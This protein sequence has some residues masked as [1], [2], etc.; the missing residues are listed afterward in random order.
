MGGIA[1]RYVARERNR[2]RDFINKL[3]AGFRMLLPN[4]IHVFEDLDK[5]GRGIIEHTRERIYRRVS[6]AALTS[7]VDPE[8][9]SK[10]CPRC[11]YVVETQEGQIFKCPRCNLKMN[12]QKAA[13][14]NIRRRYLER[15]KKSETR[16]RGS[17]TAMN[18]K[19]LL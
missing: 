18:Q 6:E 16:M 1:Q 13:S 8:N 10:E 17:P 11:R 14:I 5:R 12:R 19:R 15:G 9:T 2:K 3:S 4:S 7:F